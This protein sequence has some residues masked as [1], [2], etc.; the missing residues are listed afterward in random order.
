LEAYELL[1]NARLVQATGDNSGYGILP[2]LAPRARG[3]RLVLRTLSGNW[4]L[5]WQD[6]DEE[7]T[8]TLPAPFSAGDYQQFRLRKEG[9]RLAIFWENQFIGSVPVSG[10]ATRVGLFGRRGVASFDQVRVMAI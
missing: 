2:A 3:P 7:Q 4:Q 1:V 9:K 5:C 10:A 6:G 8:F